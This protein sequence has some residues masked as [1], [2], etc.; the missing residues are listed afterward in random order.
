MSERN[1]RRGGEQ[2]KI[3]PE[4]GEDNF[5]VGDVV[6]WVL[7]DLYELAE[8][9]DEIGKLAG[10]GDVLSLE[11]AEELQELRSRLDELTSEFGWGR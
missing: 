2:G 9:H 7:E 11:E 5:G 10:S 3:G 1:A 6:L 8:L 4:A